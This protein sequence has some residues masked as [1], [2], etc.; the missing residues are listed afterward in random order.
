LLGDL[1][2]AKD[3]FEVKHLTRLQG[4]DKV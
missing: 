1:R 4:H 3:T 2:V